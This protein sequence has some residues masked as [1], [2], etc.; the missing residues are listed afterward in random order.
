MNALDKLIEEHASNYSTPAE[1]VWAIYLNEQRIHTVS[2]KSSWR[3]IG[4]AKAA[5]KHHLD[6]NMAFV[7]EYVEL[8]GRTSQSVCNSVR[9]DDIEFVVNDLFTRGVLRFVQMTPTVSS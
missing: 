4:H 1:T 9:K 7:A 8:N 5:F 3:T 6:Y 2:G